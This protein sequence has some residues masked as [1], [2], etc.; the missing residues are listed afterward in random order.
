MADT[1][2]QLR[3]GTV[4]LG[5]MGLL[6]VT[7]T[8]CSSG[9]DPDKRCV[10]RNSYTYGKGYRVVADKNC[11]TTKTTVN[12]SWYY[13]G[14]KKRGWVKDGSFVKPGKGGSGGSGGSGSY[15]GGHSG[16]HRGGFG[17][18]HGGYGG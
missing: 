17:G 5:G 9:S 15:D 11:T 1:R 2:R 13:G 14:K 4:L 8:A 12:G 7:L 6:A 10:D 18:G 3:S 16:V